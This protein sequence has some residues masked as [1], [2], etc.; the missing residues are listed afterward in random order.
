MVVVFLSIALVGLT[1]TRTFRNYLRTQLIAEL[2]PLVNGSIEIGPIEGNLGTGFRIDNIGVKKDGIEIFF[3]ER[4]EVRYDLLGVLVRRASISRLTLLRPRINLWRTSGG[5]WNIDQLFVAQEDRDTA[6]SPWTLD[7][8]QIELLGASVSVVDSF[9]LASR[10]APDW[11]AQPPGSLDYADLHLNP[12]TLRGGVQLQGSKTVIAI[13]SL[14]FESLRPHFL[15]EQLSG[16]FSLSPNSTEVRNLVVRTPGV[17]LRLNARMTGSNPLAINHLSDLENAQT[18]LNLSVDKLDFGTLKRFLPGPVDFLDKQAALEVVARGTFGHLII[19]E[20]QVKTPR[21]YI[22]LSGTI[23]NL[24]HPRNLILDLHATDNIL[25]PADAIDLLPG[26]KLPDLRSL[27]VVSCNYSFRGRPAQFSASLDGQITAGHFAVNATMDLEPDAMVYDVEFATKGLD[28]ESLLQSERMKSSLNMTGM[29]SGSGTHIRNLTSLFRVRVDSSLLF[30]QPVENSVLVVDVADRSLRANLLLQAGQTRFDVSGRSRFRADDSTVY[31]FS[32]KVLSLN[33]ADVLSESSY[34]SDLSFDWKSDGTAFIFDPVHSRTDLTFLRSSLRGEVFDDKHVSVEYHGADSVDKSLTLSSEPFD[35]AVEGSF[36]PAALIEAFRA[37]GTILAEAITHRLASLDSLRSFSSR[38]RPPFRSRV[39]LSSESV[40]ANVEVNMRDFYP[41]GV[42]LG[43]PMQGASTLHARIEGPLSDLHF[44]GQLDMD[45]FTLGLLPSRFDVEEGKSTFALS[46]LG[47]TRT[48]ETLQSSIDFSARKMQVDSLFFNNV[49]FMHRLNNDSSDYSLSLL[50]DSTVAIRATGSSSYVPHR[51]NLDVTTLNVKLGDYGFE[52][53]DPIQLA[54]GRDG[55][56]VSSLS[57]QHEAE[58]VSFSGILDPAGVSDLKFSLE[59]FLIRNLQNFSRHQSY[60]EKVRD[61][62]GILDASGSFSGNFNLPQFDLSLLARGVTVGP[63]VFGQISGKGS[64]RDGV[65]DVFLEFRTK[66]EERG[67]EPELLVSGRMP[68]NLG[69]VP[70]SRSSQ[71]MDLTIHSRGFKLE[72]LDPFLP[73]T[74]S[75]TGMVEA[76]LKMKGTL[77][78]PMYEGSLSIQHASFFFVPL[79]VTYQLNGALLPVGRKITFRD[80]VLSNV[81]EDRVPGL[82]DGLGAMQIQGGLTLEGLQVKDFD[83]IARGQLLVLKESSRLENFPMYG[84]VY[85]GS[86]TIPLHWAGA[87][88]KSSLTGEV[89]VKNATITFPPTREVILERSRLFTVLFVDDTTADRSTAAASDIRPGNG[90]SLTPLRELNGDQAREESSFLDNIVYN[91]SIETAGLT[92][93]RFVFNQLTNEELFAD[94][95][96]R[97]VFSK[98]MSA[99]RL[100]GELQVGSRSYYKYFKT[101][102]ATGKI[103]F[104]GDFSD[105]ELDIVATYEGT[106]QPDTMRIGVTDKDK[107]EQKV[108]VRLTITGT[109][110]EPKVKM[111]LEVFDRDGNK[112]EQRP[113]AQSD[114]IAFLV[115]GRFKDEMTQG[116][117]TSLTTSLLSSIGTSLLSGPLTDFVRKQIGYVTS[118]DVAYYAGANRSFSQAADLRITGEVGDAVIRLGGRVFSGD[119]SNANVSVQFPMSSIVGSEAWRNLILEIERRVEGVESIE[120]RR[121]S[122]GLRLLYRITF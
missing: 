36:T 32:G 95:K 121:P 46:R 18:R 43:Q 82:I 61:F 51:I 117:E 93:V 103:L 113:D 14:D 42:F 77:G 54:F 15:M 52:N 41:L 38:E 63:A 59:N 85:I 107:L 33:L 76:D 120:Q 92:Q 25:H 90:N 79:G 98:D 47:P 106:H 27:G 101:L 75:L 26:L 70:S 56:K 122:N 97:L 12:L 22:R 3:A 30:N 64:Y 31:S 37:G 40:S 29:L 9:A 119:L 65:S 102:Q 55:I 112:L 58:S 72:F 35:V 19:E 45:K 80:L 10:T 39:R 73:I 86:G 57:L 24:H 110:T 17:A 111:G 104:T 99:A 71:D 94:L 115:S 84:N 48:L 88:E 1:Q 69:S 7:F 83:L 50:V 105:P 67:S 81:D 62:N 100:T 49:V 23:D 91:L 13:Q 116:Q 78:E 44:S 34:E 66:P 2:Q 8:R 87:P 28:L 114:A 60:V 6:S 74:R 108:L 53:T 21:T 4:L 11:E 16:E 89:L 109:R 118:V 68:M 5:D 20:V 96:G